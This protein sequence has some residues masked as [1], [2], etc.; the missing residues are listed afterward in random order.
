MGCG[1]CKFM[2]LLWNYRFQVCWVMKEFHGVPAA[3]K[4][5]I[6]VVSVLHRSTEEIGRF[7]CIYWQ[8]LSV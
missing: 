4:A 7:N 1:S 5:R 2:T 3:V 8:L 6:I